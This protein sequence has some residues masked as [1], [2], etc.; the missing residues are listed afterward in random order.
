[1]A[2]RLAHRRFE[3]APQYG[4]DLRSASI[5]MLVNDGDGAMIL[6]LSPPLRDC[7][8]AVTFQVPDAR[9]TPTV[10]FGVTTFDAPSDGLFSPFPAG[11]WG[12]TTSP[13]Y[14]SRHC[15]NDDPHAVFS[16]AI[17]QKVSLI[18][19]GDSITFLVDVHAGAVRL[20]LN[21]K[22][23]GPPE[24][25]WTRANV[26]VPDFAALRLYIG[27]GEPKTVVQLLDDVP[28][29]PAEAPAAAAATPAPAAGAQGPGRS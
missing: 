26:P 21:G 28:V 29:P 17:D 11:C 12:A 14:H 23:Y 15:T 20:L 22:P 24:G 9:G 5:T 2:G 10:T 1:M 16:D 13:G 25:V 3:A 8:P 7:D 18:K 4:A 27:I 6:P 19:V